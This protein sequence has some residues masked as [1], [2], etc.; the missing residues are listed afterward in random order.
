MVDFAAQVKL[1][2]DAG[3]SADP[4]QSWPSSSGTSTLRTRAVR[5]AQKGTRRGAG[6]QDRI[7]PECLRGG[8]ATVSGIHSLATGASRTINLAEGRRV[9]AAVQS[10]Y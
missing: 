5:P 2:R 10:V 7:H 8:G 4:L 3:R 9:G 6:C 1:T